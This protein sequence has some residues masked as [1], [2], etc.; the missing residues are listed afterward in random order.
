MSMLRHW[1][2]VLYEVWNI[3]ASLQQLDGEYDLN[4]LVT[5]TGNQGDYILKVM[6]QG[7]AADFIDMQCRALA[8]ISNKAADIPVPAVIPTQNEELFTTVNNENGEPRL[9]W[10]LAKAEGQVYAHYKPH[11]PA[12][13]HNIGAELGRVDQ[14]LAD[15]SHPELQRDIKWN[16]MRGDWI[17]QHLSSISHPQ[18]QDILRGIIHDFLSAKPLLEGLPQQAI[19]N[20]VNDYN[21]II[22]GSLTAPPQI[23][24]LIDLGDMCAC[25]RICDLAIAAA[26]MVLDHPEPEAALAALVQGYHQQYPLTPAELDLLWPLLRMRLAV[27]VVNSTLM[28][29]DK[30]DDPYVLISQRPAWEFLQGQAVNGEL[31]SA[32]LRAAC[33]LPVTDSAPR[34]LAWLEQARGSF[35]PLLGK[36]LDHA[37]MGSLA[38][39]DVATPQNPFDMPLAEAATIGQQY[40][41]H[42]E[43]W[44]GYYGEPRLVYTSAAFY[45]GPWQASDRRTVHLAVDIFAPAGTQLH[46]PMAATVIAAENRPD[47]LDYGGVVILRHET[48]QGEAFFTLYGHLNPEVCTNLTIGQELQQGEAFARLGDITQSGGWAP[49]THVQ[50]ALSTA[51]MGNDW[52][53]VASPDDM[54]IWSKLCPNPAALLNLPDE[55]VRYL[56]VG[57]TDV[58]ATRHRHFSRN[59]KLSYHD[60]LMLVR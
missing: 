40:A 12:L 25:P 5:G 19:H 4:F 57:K 50:L 2:Q 43:V 42:G 49:H 51:G 28:A 46:A 27:S 7:C 33:N 23:S 54:Y 37:A 9:L 13:I 18:Q 58:L 56:P 48:P 32:R 20:D 35:A 59:L 6:R 1:Q 11:S 22:K 14:A 26:Y 38:V 10:L 55:K 30:P 44:L 16:L 36:T 17:K 24:A 39:S 15:F 29:Q 53:G 3:E 31:L 8:H 52:P 41:N 60:P 21:I 34:I 47:H 45:N